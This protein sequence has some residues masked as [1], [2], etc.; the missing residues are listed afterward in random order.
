MLYRRLTITAIVAAVVAAGL[1]Y[2]RMDSG[3]LFAREKQLP[4][5]LPGSPLPSTP[6]VRVSE[7]LTTPLEA[8]VARLQPLTRAMFPSFWDTPAKEQPPANYTVRDSALR[9]VK[10]TL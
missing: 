2:S 9:V 7:A 1:L 3:G 6:V 5:L 4:R 8:V 10:G